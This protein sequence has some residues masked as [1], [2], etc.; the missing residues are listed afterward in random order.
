M[1]TLAS[2]AHSCSLAAQ[3]YRRR[4]LRCGTRDGL[5]INVGVDFVPRYTAHPFK[6][7]DVLGWNETLVNPMLDSLLGK[8]EVIGARLDATGQT[9]RPLDI[10]L[11]G[12]EVHS[13]TVS[14]L[15]CDCKCGLR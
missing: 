11:L 10:R 4:G 3:G 13:Q 9:H 15:I 12:F 14:N 1:K 8:P 7:D 6:F 5:G 2:R